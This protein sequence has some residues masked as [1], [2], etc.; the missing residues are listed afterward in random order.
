VNYRHIF[1]AGN[2]ADVVKHAALALVIEHLKRKPS[3]FAVID[4]HAGIG[5]YDLTAAE[6][7]RTGEYHDGVERVMA[8]DTPPV[9]LAAYLAAVHALN[10]GEGGRLRWYPGSPRLARA[11][12]R[13]GDRLFAV[14]LHPADCEILA[15]GFRGDRQV[16]T[17]NLDGYQALASF[18]PPR[19]RRVVVLVDPP[20]EVPG[21]F[22]RLLRGLAA[23]HRRF[24]TGIYLVWYPFKE[25]A[26]IERFHRALEASGMR[27]ILFAEFMIRTPADETRLNG[28]GLVIVNPPFTIAETLARCLD[29]LVPVLA[30]GEGGGKRVVWLVPE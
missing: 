24:A 19:E 9:E 17:V 30:Q 29:A 12:M 26:P 14:E 18:V 15:A 23:A 1:H 21:E 28:C 6:A 10:E 7:A 2:F 13:P 8:L 20:Y 11:L 25:R 3:P 5:C 22:D 16:K 27:R 4:T